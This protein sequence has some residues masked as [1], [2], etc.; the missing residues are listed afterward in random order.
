MVTMLQKSAH[1]R[2]G[3]SKTITA[4]DAEAAEK[5]LPKIFFL[6]DLGALGG[7]SQV[8]SDHGLKCKTLRVL[9]VRK[10]HPRCFP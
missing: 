10:T 1:L 5:I 6:G 8:T 3:E 4:E 2:Q 7:R 9:T